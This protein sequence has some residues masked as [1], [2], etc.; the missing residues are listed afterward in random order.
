MHEV[1]VWIGAVFPIICL[2]FLIGILQIRTERAAFAGVIVAVVAAF[3]VGK[4]TW[5]GVLV[6]AGKGAWNALPI[7]V[8]IWT[9]ILLY[10]I[11]EQ[12]DAFLVIR[13]FIGKAIKD[14]LLLI[15][16]ISWI[17]AS[18]LQGITGFG[19]PVAVCAPLLI[20]MGVKP[21]WAVLITLLGHA[22]ANTFGT[23]AMGWDALL[24]QSGLTDS[25]VTLCATC[26]CLA[27]VNL[28]GAVLTCIFYGGKRAV[29]HMAPL[30]I[31]ISG[32][33]G[34]GQFMIGRI[35][36]TIAAFI[37]TTVALF[38]IVFVIKCGK[39][40][41]EWRMPSAI[42][43]NVP[44][45]AQSMIEEKDEKKNFF[46]AVF[47]FGILVMLSVLILMVKPVYERLHR[48]SLF[49]SFPQTVTGRG[50][51]NEAVGQYGTFYIFT[52][53]G[54]ILLLT[55]CITLLLYKRKN[56]IQ[57]SS[58]NR[59]GK[60]TLKKIIP[61]SVSLLFLVMMAQILKGSGLMT[62]IAEG[63][64]KV[65]GQNY[66]MAAPFIGLLGAFVTSSNTSSNILLGSFQAEMASILHAKEWILL[67]AQTVGGAIGTVIGP[68]TIFLGITT[69]GCLGKEG[70]V[71]K[72][73]FP[74]AL[75]ETAVFGL[76]SWILMKGIL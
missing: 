69:A 17:F 32:I 39:Y 2:F 14:E 29:L 31:L 43:S 20:T 44:T 53:A 65:T 11:L 22:W 71:M 61:T 21:Q 73:M 63:V 4:D 10:Q 6:S 54:F 51:T 34:V 16:L 33:H 46:Y 68:S 57:K 19:V 72:K 5:K 60:A 36:S 66:G 23:F 9:A 56:K 13:S 25:F 49:L 58:L 67:T 35:N 24:A 1:G 30:L 45:V 64:A 15:L 75:A 12:T 70:W 76:L 47:P 42:M 3:V 48:V 74:V 62:I 50:F 28:C 7:L 38:A 26:V 59:I 40:T 52:H 37:P 18:F 27:V 41:K 8:V 55:V